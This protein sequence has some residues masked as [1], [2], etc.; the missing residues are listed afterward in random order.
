[1][2]HHN[3]FFSW[4][5]MDKTQLRQ[6]FGSFMTGVTIVTAMDDDAPIGFTA[7]SFSSVSLDPALLLICID[8]ASE[9]LAAFTQ[10]TGFGVNILAHDQQDLSNRFARPIDDRFAEVDWTVTSNGNPALGGTAA[11][12][13]CRLD[14]AHIA[15]DHTILIGEVIAFQMTD[16]NGLGY[17]R[18]GYFTLDRSA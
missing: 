6:C 5:I 1:M 15:G 10:G 18:G 13:D 9:N 12:F 4:H 8:N 17:Y 3:K 7:N 16:K 2:F 11:F 14:N